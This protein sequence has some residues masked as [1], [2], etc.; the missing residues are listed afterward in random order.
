MRNPNA[1]PPWS[2]LSKPETG[3][4][5]IQSKYLPVGL[6]LSDPEK[7]SKATAERFYEHWLSRQE[8][9]KLPLCFE[10]EGGKDDGEE[11]P[12]KKEEEEEKGKEE[13]GKGKGKRKGEEM[14]PAQK[15]PMLKHRADDKLDAEPPTKKSKADQAEPAT[16]PEPSSTSHSV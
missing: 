8:Q 1:R 4:N 14:Q 2:K 3:P 5:L 12:E 10:V 11:Q 6:L 15:K 16:S 13:K 7:M 9:K